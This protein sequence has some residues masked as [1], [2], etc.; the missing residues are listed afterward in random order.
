MKLI[1]SGD[2]HWDEHERWD[3]ALRVHG[4]MVNIIRDERP[5]VFLSGGDVYERAST[6]KERAAVADWLSAVAEVCP[7][8]IAKGNHDRHL[9]CALLARLRTRHPVIVEERAGVHVV[10]GAAIAT[11]AWPERVHLL[12]AL[13]AVSGD[14]V[15]VVVNDAL[16]NVLRGLGDQLE[17]H[18]GPRILLGHFMCD[19]AET[20]TGQPLLGQPVRVG[21]ADLALAR[22]HLVLMSHIHKAQRF[23]AGGAP[24]LYMGSP[25]RT[26]FGQLERKSVVV[27][28]FDGA[29]LTELRE[30]E[31]PATPMVQL[32]YEWTSDGMFCSGGAQLHEEQLPNLLGA[33]VRFRFGVDADRREAAKAAAAQLKAEWLDMGAVNVKVEEE[34]RSVNRARAPEV[35]KAKTLEE[36]LSLLWQVRGFDPGPRREALL[37]KAR[38]L[39]GAA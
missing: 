32:E 28:T 5:D 2:H 31:T 39:K 7:V 6:P 26:T 22:S 17:A 14:A 16:C 21:L 8:V 19:G 34:V 12:A 37:E 33:E 20:S 25:F 15:D 38:G 13:G 30:V 24:A 23:D 11:V 35:S 18:D 10:G 3:E 4:W 36:K 9:D 27:A 1:A 29:T